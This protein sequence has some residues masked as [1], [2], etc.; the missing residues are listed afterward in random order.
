VLNPRFARGVS[1]GRGGPDS[2]FENYQEPVLQVATG[3]GIGGIQTLSPR[4]MTETTLPK[5]GGKTP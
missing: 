2:S 3:N 1:G 5:V 4:G